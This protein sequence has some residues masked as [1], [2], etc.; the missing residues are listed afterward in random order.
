MISSV[1]PKGLFFDTQNHARMPSRPVSSPSTTESLKRARAGFGQAFRELVSGRPGRRA[2]ALACL[3]VLLIFAALP[4]TG[5]PLRLAR[6]GVTLTIWDGPRWADETGN[7]YHWVEAKIKEFEAA[8]PF[9]EVKLV[10]VDWADLRGL[11]DSA[12][13][14]GRLPD[15]APFDIS[16]GGITPDE[17]AAGLLDPVD[18]YISAP[19]DLSPEAKAAYTYQGQLWGFPETMTG[20]ALL[21]NLDLFAKRGVTPP[22]DGKW[23]WAE[24]RDACIRLTF[25]SNGDGKTDTYGFSTYVLPGYYEAWPFL[26]ADGARPLS[27]DLKTY[28][29]NSPQ[30]VAALKRLSDLILVD[31]AAHPMTGSASVRNIF[32]L[33]ANKDKQQV[34]IEPWSAWAID[35]LKTQEN[36]IQNFAV[37]EFPAGT[38][39]NA[40]TVGGTSGFVVFHQEDSGRRNL[41]MA[42][43]DYLTNATSQYELATG[44][45]A[46]PS[47]QEA[48]D[49]DPFAGDPAYQQAAKV[50][51]H[52]VSLPAA[53]RWPDLERVIQREIQ[54]AILGVK[55]PQEALDS[56]GSVIT[57]LLQPPAPGGG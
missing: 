22:A 20:Q 14:A 55:S 36:M 7:R 5:C 49:L 38:S 57:P 3:A 10:P 17:L 42:L 56:A 46:F 35:Y 51:F 52:A 48:L 24:F 54:M 40:L 8:H 21:L 4:F 26:Y 15:V 39:G 25:D 9:V 44:Y 30:G 23:T 37:A 27:E 50:I 53:P 29:L 32:D 45:H 19:D 31:K 2:V 13:E 43:A 11:L 1:R 33:F 12:K 41:A 16:S 47:R 28:T 34:A 18:G 6:P